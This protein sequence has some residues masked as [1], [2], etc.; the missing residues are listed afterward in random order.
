MRKR[1]RARTLAATELIVGVG[2]RDA[3]EPSACALCGRE[4]ADLTKHHVRPRQ[5]GG[6]ETEWICSACHRQVHALFT[7]RT[8]ATELDTLEKLKAAPEMQR[9]LAWARR[10]ADGRI[11]VRRS[12]SR[13]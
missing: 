13:R 1:D 6:T 2:R 12:R 8:L 4:V 5:Y 3:T 10:Q 11:S 9:Y 7:N